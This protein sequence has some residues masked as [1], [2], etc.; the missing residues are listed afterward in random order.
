MTLLFAGSRKR[1]DPT[2][3]FVTD[4]YRRGQKGVFFFHTTLSYLIPV[5]LVFATLVN[6]SNPTIFHTFTTVTKNK[7]QKIV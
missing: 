4:I 5:T 3:T 2:V 6:F 7:P 1:F